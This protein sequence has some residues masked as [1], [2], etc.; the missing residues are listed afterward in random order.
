MPH[1]DAFDSDVFS[2]NSLTLALLDQPHIPRRL[3]ELGIFEEDGVPTTDISIEKDTNTLSLVQTSPRGAPAQTRT[4]DP[5]TMFKIPSVRVAYE[6][7]VMA[8]EV[9]NLRAFGSENDL[10]T[11]ENEVN[12]RMV[13]LSNDVEATLEYHRATCIAGNVLD[14]DGSTLYDMA[15]LFGVAL[16]SSVDF[17]M[18]AADSPAADGSLRRTCSSIIRTIED[19]LGDL[20]YDS[21]HAMCGSNFFDDLTAH[22]EYRAHKLSWE[23]ATQL[24]ERIARR[25]VQ[26]GGITFEE[27]RGTVG[28]TA[29]VNTDQAKFFPIGT[30]GLFITRYSPAEYWDTVNTVGLP[31]YVR[32]VA[33][34]NLDP[35]V[36]RVFRVQAHPTTLCTR[37]GVLVPATRT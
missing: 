26:F 20:P 8:D 5:R 10:Q 14:A 21:I 17:A 24:D 13:R 35:D 34:N 22:P 28:G 3:G 6:D 18:D 11:L 32:Q 7:A 30:P 25:S 33:S 36:G 4:K 31:R 2:M 1:M 23:A 12:N 19:A 29:Y 9:Q 15:T 27:Y 16:P 37:P